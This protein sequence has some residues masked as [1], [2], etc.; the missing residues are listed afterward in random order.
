MSIVYG[1]LHI[2]SHIGSDLQIVLFK[3]LFWA[4]FLGKELFLALLWALFK[5]SE[6][7]LAL[8]CALFLALFYGN[9]FVELIMAL[10]W[11]LLIEIYYLK[12]FF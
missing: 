9:F 7:F 6:L 10:F 4:L 1:S 12:F 3:V 8:F 11:E 2:F 5:V